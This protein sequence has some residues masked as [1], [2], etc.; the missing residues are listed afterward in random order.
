MVDSTY[1]YTSLTFSQVF[2]T[3]MMTTNGWSLHPFTNTHLGLSPRVRLNKPKSC[4]ILV[5]CLSVS[6]ISTY[7]SMLRMLSSATFARVDN[8][9]ITQ[10]Y[11]AVLL[12]LHHGY[13]V[14]R[15]Q[16]IIRRLRRE[17]CSPVSC[18][19]PSIF[20]SAFALLHSLSC[21]H[22]KSPKAVGGVRRYTKMTT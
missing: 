15:T 22:P 10:L 3:D 9:H 17:Q 16:A 19:C 8:P 21:L 13:Q 12:S 14:R 18:T 1:R 7:L 2:N 5:E 11:T 6:R 4:N 20:A